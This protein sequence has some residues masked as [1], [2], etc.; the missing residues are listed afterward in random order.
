MVID[1]GVAWS[2]TLA[3]CADV[4]QSNQPNAWSS[5]SP[6]TLESVGS[7]SASISASLTNGAAGKPSQSV[8][9]WMQ[10]GT[11]SASYPDTVDRH[12]QHDVA[13]DVVVAH[14]EDE[15]RLGGVEG[16]E[17]VLAD[18]DLR[19]AGVAVGPLVD[20]LGHGVGEQGAGPRV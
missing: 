14:P 3:V 18:L 2:E 11:T 1:S 8:S 7:A 16:R 6:P 12:A 5:V 10:Y 20:R 17:D 13:V 15:S 9:Y 4:L 19:G